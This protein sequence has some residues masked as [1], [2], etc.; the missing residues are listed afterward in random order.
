MRTAQALRSIAELG[1]VRWECYVQ[2]D[3][4]DRKLAEWKSRGKGVCIPIEIVIFGDLQHRDTVGS[5][6]SKARLYLQRPEHEVESLYDNPH[7]MILPHTGANVLQPQTRSMRG[8]E[9][10]KDLVNEVLGRLDHE[11]VLSVEPRAHLSTILR[12]QLLPHQ[13]SAVDFIAQREGRR[14]TKLPSLWTQCG[15]GGLQCYEHKI[16]GTRK[17]RPQ[18]DISGG[19]LADEMGLGK[20]LTILAAIVDSF[21][22]ANVFASDKL[23]KVNTKATLVIMPSALLIDEWMSNIDEHAPD[24]LQVLKYHGSKRSSR[25]DQVF[26]SDVVLTTYATVSAEFR[27]PSSPLFHFNWFRIVLDEAHSIRHDTTNQFHAVTSLT[28]KYRWCLSGTPFQNTL[29]DFGALFRFLRIPLLDNKPIFRDQIVKPTEARQYHGI[30]RL[31]VILRSICIRRTNQI[32]NLPEP[33]IIERPV[34]FSSQEWEAYNQIGA[35]AK[36]QMEDAIHGRSDEKAYSIMLRTLT[37]LRLFCN[38]GTLA[39]I[40]AFDQKSDVGDETLL[41]QLQQTDEAVCATCS[42]DVLSVSR[43]DEAGS[44]TFNSHRQL[45]CFDCSVQNNETARPRERTSQSLRIRCKEVQQ[46][47]SIAFLGISDHLSMKSEGTSSKLRAVLEDLQKCHE[48]E[49]SI[50]F[51]SWKMTLHMLA[52]ML[53]RAQIHYLQIDGSQSLVERQ[54]TLSQFKES[55]EFSILLMTLGTG[56]VGLNL[57]AASRI[58]LVEPHWNPSTERQAIGRALRLGQNKE[59]TVMQYFM[60]ESVEVRVRNRQAIKD[61]LSRAS[62]ATSEAEDEKNKLAE[63]MEVLQ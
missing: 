29:Y 48:G 61:H 7:E 11:E 41:T 44:G 60:E 32:L 40:P 2:A 47:Q 21:A 63:L 46:P 45:L 56:A 37:R 15:K 8:I 14:D 58:H 20:T 25:S 38:Q 5:I 26:A 59:V 35:T 4:L 3:D 24:C 10:S 39:G 50:V 42:C 13:L 17:A 18:P 33:R 43:I 57:T 19:I 23:G 12:T 27:K 51:S 1:A 22:T 30:E 31:Q 6:L 53:E 28:A 62:W 49:K 34:Q 36:E 9:D 55:D 54:K 52:A 16:T